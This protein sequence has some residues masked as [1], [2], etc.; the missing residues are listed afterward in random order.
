M[1]IGRGNRS[2]R[3]KSTPMPLR[4]PQILYEGSNSGRR[5]RKPTKTIHIL[6]VMSVCPHV[7]GARLYDRCRSNY[8]N[9]ALTFSSHLWICDHLGYDTVQSDGHVSTFWK[10]IIVLVLRIYFCPGDLDRILKVTFY[11]DVAGSMFLRYLGAT[12]LYTPYCIAW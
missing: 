2:S 4:P 5:G 1:R 7:T 11:P 6:L 8:G 12:Y 3:R 10:I 9:S